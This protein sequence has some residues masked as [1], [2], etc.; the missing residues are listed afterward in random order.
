[1]SS[2]VHYESLVDSCADIFLSRLDEFAR[3]GQSLNLAHWLQ[4]YAFDVIGN[5]TFG[6]RFGTQPFKTW[7]HITESYLK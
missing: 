7:S 5:L 1:M 2:L 4:C 3:N 6:E